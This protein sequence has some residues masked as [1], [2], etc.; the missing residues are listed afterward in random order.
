VT[1][2]RADQRD[3]WTGTIVPTMPNNSGVPTW[4]E[5]R[6]ASVTDGTSNTLLLGEKFVPVDHHRTALAWGDNEHWAQGNRWVATRHA[7]H[8][9][10]RDSRETTATKEV[11]PPNAP[12]AGGACGPWG[13]GPVGSGGGYYDYWGSAHPG[14]FNVALTDGSVRIIQYTINL[15]VLQALSHRGDGQVVNSGSL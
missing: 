14:G 12:S 8:Q 10:R 13:L 7:I 5:L 15:Q 1:W 3:T 2:C 4:P 6:F 9:P 11:P